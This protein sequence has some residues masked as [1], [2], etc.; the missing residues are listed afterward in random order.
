M[1]YYILDIRKAFANYKW[2]V[3][4]E[5]KPFR[6]RKEAREFVSRIKNENKG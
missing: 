3:E 1:K 5:G 2:I 4:P 6:I